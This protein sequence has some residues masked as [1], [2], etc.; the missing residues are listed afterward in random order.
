MT[1]TL[2][3]VLTSG[4]GRRFVGRAAEIELFRAALAADEPPFSV[5]Y[6]HGPA[7]IGKTSLLDVLSGIAQADA[8]V[9]RLDGRDLV[10]TPPGILDGLRGVLH[11]PAGDGRIDGSPTDGRLAVL[12][13][14]Y[15]RI[16]PLD[17]WVRIHLLPRLPS[18]ALT[19]L[20][21]RTPPTTAWRADPAWRELLRVVSLRNLSPEESQQYLDACGVDSAACS[22]VAPPSVQTRR[23]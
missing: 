11:V 13:D 1:G 14:S 21:S 9:I 5:L 2:G 6:L 16:A 20:A 18:N 22:A 3:D 12:I 19:V 8:T 15:E 4:R 7:G 23:Q 17:D 10:P